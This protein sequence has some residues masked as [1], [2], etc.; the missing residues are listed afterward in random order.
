[1]SVKTERPQ[2]RT[3][4]D[5]ERKYALLLNSGTAIKQTETGLVKVNNILSEFIAAT[6]G[7]L[8]TLQDQLDGQLDT[9][10]G[11]YHPTLLTEPTTSWQVS[12]YDDHVGDLF[13]DNST[14]ITYKFSEESG[15]YSWEEVDS[16]LMSEI[17]AMANSAKDTADNKRRVFVSQPTPP[18][19]T[20]DLWLNDQE[21][22]VCQIARQTGSYTSG[23]FIIATK[24][25][26]DTVALS[27]QQ[28]AAI[29]QQKALDV[30]ATTDTLKLNF[31]KRLVLDDDTVIDEKYS[32]ITFEDGSIVFSA[33]DA[34]IKMVI[35][36]D[37][38]EFRDAQSNKIL[39]SWSAEE[40]IATS[41]TLN[42]G[43]FAFIPRDNGSL[44]FRKVN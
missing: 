5:L 40:Q 27:A 43:N 6:I 21:L 1:M 33:G 12:E 34:R 22:Y 17:L 18:Y 42:L 4:Q 30:E 14:G 24:Y 8:E 36:N 28:A 25:T 13:Y 38:I 20:G 19:E 35:D 31:E 41:T 29:A 26:D 15:V 44:G 7:D 2:V 37:S 39:A 9:W 3:A 32:T 10:Y 11:D 23:D 16:S